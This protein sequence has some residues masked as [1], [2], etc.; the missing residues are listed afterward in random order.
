LPSPPLPH[1]DPIS[2]RSQA[3]A[4]FHVMH[5]FHPWFPF[6][7]NNRFS[8]KPAQLGFLPAN[9]TRFPYRQ[10][11]IVHFQPT[12][13]RTSQSGTIGLS[14]KPVTELLTV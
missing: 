5:T 14:F 9:K 7:Q 3:T 8:I 2:F 4:H 6:S 13:L 1:A 12:S 11:N 10:H